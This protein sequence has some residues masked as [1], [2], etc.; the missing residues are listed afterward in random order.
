MSLRA[1]TVGALTTVRVARRRILSTRVLALLGASKEAVGSVHLRAMARSKNP[2]PYIRGRRVSAG[3][4]GN[5]AAANAIVLAK[6]AKALNVVWQSVVE[7]GV[8]T[9]EDKGAL[10]RAGAAL[11]I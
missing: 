4:Q 10:R 1:T 2:N 5:E 6:D 8:F 11:G 9:D 7:S 3:K